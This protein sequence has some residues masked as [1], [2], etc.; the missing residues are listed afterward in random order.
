MPVR[1]ACSTCGTIVETTAGTGRVTWRGAC[2]DT[3]CAGYVIAR[4][5]HAEPLR[6]RQPDP[7]A[8]ARGEGVAPPGSTLLATNPSL[9]HADNVDIDEQASA[10]ISPPAPAGRQRVPYVEYADAHGG[11]H[12]LKAGWRAGGGP[13]DGGEPAATEPEPR[14]APAGEKHVADE[15]EAVAHSRE[16]PR[17]PTLLA[18]WR[19]QRQARRAA[20]PD[21]EYRA[22]YE[23]LN[24]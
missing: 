24:W 11:D 8:A 16:A 5:I 12:D 21:L 23:F 18:R 7:P 14:H 1:G 10:A 2:P 17:S 22:P 6:L 4:R 19:A 3:S 13:D 9:L 15:P 20:K